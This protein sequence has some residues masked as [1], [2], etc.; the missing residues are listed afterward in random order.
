MYNWHIIKIFL[1]FENN[2]TYSKQKI[3]IGKKCMTF[4]FFQFNWTYLGPIMFSGLTHSSN[5]SAVIPFFS[6]D[7]FNVRFSAWACFAILA[8]WKN[9]VLFDSVKLEDYNKPV[10]INMS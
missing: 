2:N 5:C 7:S 4:N 1:F 6:A 9:I 3:A 8:A 10:I